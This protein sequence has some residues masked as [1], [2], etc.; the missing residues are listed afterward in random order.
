ML[1]VLLSSKHDIRRNR[2][3][4]GRCLQKKLCR[5]TGLLFKE[6]EA[7]IWCNVRLEYIQCVP[8]F[9]RF[10]GL[11]INIYLISIYF[12]QFSL[13]VCYNFLFV[14]IYVFPFCMCLHLI[15]NFCKSTV[16]WSC[17]RFLDLDFMFELVSVFLESV[18]CSRISNFCYGSVW[19]REHIFFLSY[20]MNRLL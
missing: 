13:C 17:F 15:F 4:I 2:C 1:K 11:E 10:F 12:I 19:V 8:T 7:A 3:W 14:C 5:S 18:L 16:M 6:D 9:L 20:C